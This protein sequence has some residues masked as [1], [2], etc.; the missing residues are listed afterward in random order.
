VRAA[1][2]TR[3]W[4][5]RCAALERAAAEA[6]AG[7]GAHAGSALAA[8]DAELRTMAAEREAL[9]VEGAV[10]ACVADLCARA[11]AADALRRA[12]HAER[13]ASVHDAAADGKARAPRAPREAPAPSGS[14][15]R[16]CDRRKEIDGSKGHTPPPVLQWGC[17]AG[18]AGAGGRRRGA[19]APTPCAP[20]EADARW[21]LWSNGHTVGRAVGGKVG[22]GGGER[23]I[24]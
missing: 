9:R 21:G 2:E 5:E 17:K 14:C 22:E 15:R 8:K 23:Q 20:A 13:R 16:C 10:A 1:A 6:R 18:P 4:A 11:E 24:R 12:A 3:G 19:C 7:A